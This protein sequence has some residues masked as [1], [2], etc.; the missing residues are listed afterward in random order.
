LEPKSI[1]FGGGPTDTVVHPI[2]LLLVVAAGMLI[3]FRPR[4][5]AI[6]PFI[7]ASTFPNTEG[8]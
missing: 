4:S 6:A 7:A 5:R 3:L 2:V 8:E 1:H